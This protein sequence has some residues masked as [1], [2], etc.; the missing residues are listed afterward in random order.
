VVYGDETY[1]P[2]MPW[3]EGNCTVGLGVSFQRWQKLQTTSIQALIS[4]SDMLQKQISYILDWVHSPLANPSL[5]RCRAT[6]TMATVIAAGL[7]LW[8]IILRITHTFQSTTVMSSLLSNSDWRKPGKR[9][10]IEETGRIYIMLQYNITH[11][12]PATWL[13]M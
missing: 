1:V 8:T 12:Q 4:E 3:N 5:P 7:C 9:G 13:E 6:A 2:L 11:Q 10:T